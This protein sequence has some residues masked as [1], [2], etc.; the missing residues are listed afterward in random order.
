M[1]FLLLFF[2]VVCSAPTSLSPSVVMEHGLVSHFANAPHYE[3]PSGIKTLHRIHSQADQYATCAVMAP[4]D[5]MPPRVGRATFRVLPYTSDFR[6]RGFITASVVVLSVSVFLGLQTKFEL[7]VSV[8]TTLG[9]LLTACII[10]IFASRSRLASSRG[11]FA[12]VHSSFVSRERWSVT[13]SSIK[14]HRVMPS[15]GCLAWH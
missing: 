11:H 14:S 2:S 3:C 10:I 12:V 9:L 1:L 8:T 13:R 7:H 15:I 5:S 6:S 4:V